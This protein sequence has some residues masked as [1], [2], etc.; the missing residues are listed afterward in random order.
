[1]KRMVGTA[2]KNNYRR[3]NFFTDYTKL[4]PET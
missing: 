4:R 3:F 1:M 2:R